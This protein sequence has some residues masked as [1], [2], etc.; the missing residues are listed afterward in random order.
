VRRSFPPSQGKKPVDAPSFSSA[1]AVTAASTVMATAPTTESSLNQSGTASTVE[2]SV[3]P[4]QSIDQSQTSNTS[5]SSIMSPTSTYTVR[6]YDCGKPSSLRPSWRRR[7]C[8][9]PPPPPPKPITPSSSGK[10]LHLGHSF[11]STS[12]YTK[13]SHLSKSLI[14]TVKVPCC[15]VLHLVFEDP[16]SKDHKMYKMLSGDV[17]VR[18]L[19]H[20]GLAGDNVFVGHHD[21][22][23]QG[24]FPVFPRGAQISG[25][26]MGNTLVMFKPWERPWTKE[27]AATAVGAGAAIDPVHRIYSLQVEGFLQG[28]PFH[29]TTFIQFYHTPTGA[30]HLPPSELWEEPFACYYTNAFG[31]HSEMQEG[32]WP[33]A[34]SNFN[35]HMDVPRHHRLGG[36]MTLRSGKVLG[37]EDVVSRIAFIRDLD[38][39]SNRTNLFP[40]DDYV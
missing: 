40:L 31:L 16:E 17:Y 22:N 21:T 18:L 10:P 5:S 36:G 30:H 7:R 37:H 33:G 13:L 1:A 20:T 4:G 14:S 12:T 26:D 8:R 6:L 29:S 23:H 39:R 27:V 34:S 15:E 24:W 35:Q 19:D 28:A 9:R 38:T 3:S 32:Y 25:T 2:E 11:S